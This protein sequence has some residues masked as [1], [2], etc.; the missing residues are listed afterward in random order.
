MLQPY[1]DR[2]NA[3][4]T[5]S[6]YSNLLSRMNELTRADI[7]FRIAETPCF[8]SRELMKELADTGAE[9][10]HQLLN[11]PA[12]MQ[13]SEQTVPEQYRVPNEN[14]QPNFMAIDFGL[15]RNPD[16]T[17]TP[18]LVELQAF[19]SIFGYQDALSRQYIESYGLDPGLQW[20]LG[21][22]TEQTYWQLLRQVI[23]GN[24]DRENVVLLEVDP[25]QQKTLPDFHVHEDKLGIATV[26]IATLSKRGNCLVY[27][28]DGREIPI[29]RIY[30]RTIVDEL[31]RRNIQLP[32][33]YRDDLQV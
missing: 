29:H 19:P 24:H 7:S 9:L 17:L 32:F 33:D 27:H 26:D 28:R 2:F 13:A 4:F 1:R 16:G 25:Q 14:A 11:D 23:L 21:N 12:Y 10:T 20:H 3:Q 30:N 31:Q 6:G 18:K 22:H 15:V 8:F 5:A